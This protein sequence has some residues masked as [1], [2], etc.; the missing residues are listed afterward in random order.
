MKVHRDL[1]NLPQFRNAVITIGSFDGVHCG[2]QKIIKKVKDLSMAT[3]GES[4]VITFHPHPRQIVFPKDDS[5]KLITTTAEKTALL[6]KTGIDHLVIVPFTFEFSQLSADEYIQKFLVGRFQ[7]KYIVI[8]YDHRFGLNRRGDINYLKWHEKSGD[9]KVVEIEK[10]E[11][12]AIAV[13]STKIREFLETGN[14]KGAAN[15][16]HHFFTL[17]GKVVKGQ[18]IG[19]TIGY[20]TANI[21]VGN[22]FKMIPPDGIYAAFANYGGERHEAMLYIG[23]RPTL[24]AYLNKTIEVHIFDFSKTIYDDEVQV[25]IVE[26]IRHDAK[27]ENLDS[28]K[29]Q[30]Y[31]DQEAAK[32]ILK[33]SGGLVKKWENLLLPSVDIVILNYNGRNF[34]EKH[35]PSVMRTA[36]PNCQVIVA[37]N[38]SKDDSID[39]LRQHYPQVPVIEL[40]SNHG[41]AKGYN[42]ALKDLEPDYFILLNSDV[43]VPEY[44]L[45]PLVELMEKDRT[46]AA[47]QPKIRA[48]GQPEFFEYAG[49]AGGWIDFMGYP[50]CRGRIFS[51]VEKDKGQYD[52]SREIFWASGCCMAVRAP[53]FKGFGGFDDDFFAHL[54]EIDLCWRMK[55]AGYKVMFTP[56]STVYHLG[57]GTLAYHSPYKTYLNFRNS[58]YTLLKN[59][60]ALKLAYLIP[61]RLVM[62]TLAAFTFLMQAKWLHAQ[63]VFGA[64]LSFFLGLIKFTKKRL[65]TESLVQKVRISPQP[66]RQG[67]L[68]KS[69]VLQYYLFQKKFFNKL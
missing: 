48:L 37:D 31:K 35:L 45:E 17:T 16:M 64:F 41:F 30:L 4:I 46:I 52:Q 57:G 49:A 55:R 40:Q 38:A 58:Y 33:N 20:P 23:N 6:E 8:G 39:F 67:V 53:L 27:M 5:L 13:S 65:D 22:T 15:L 11:I 18:Q 51:T 21:E 61:L 2:H 29:E 1:N 60:M 50:F 19:A 62:D 66:N 42:L 14:M 69:I 59:E 56:R 7:P 32:S 10:E 26:F 43:E 24:K 63:A 9:Y 34:L 44:W 47:A 54:E 12:N 68:P 25:E 36:Y 3:G 28:L